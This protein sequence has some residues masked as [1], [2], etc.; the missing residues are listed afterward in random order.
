M[1][2]ADWMNRNLDSRIELCFPIYD[3][4]IRQ[5]V[6]DILHLQLQDNTKA[7]LLDKDHNNIPPPS[8]GLPGIRAQSETYKLLK[9]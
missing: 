4:L 6:M 5:E 3:K 8:E 9:G 7:R 2:S 1:A